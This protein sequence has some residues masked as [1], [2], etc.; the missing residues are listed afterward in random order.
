MPSPVCPLLSWVAPVEPEEGGSFSQAA[1]NIW[2]ELDS[3]VGVDLVDPSLSAGSHL[4][5]FQMSCNMLQ[6]PNST[7]THGT[8]SSHLAHTTPWPIW[9]FNHLFSSILTLFTL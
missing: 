4:Q 2:K 9:E 6:D 1:T 7:V 8:T 5:S 3:R